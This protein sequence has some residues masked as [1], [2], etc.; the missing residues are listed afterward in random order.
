MSIKL[1]Q[2]ALE[3][4]EAPM[5]NIR[6]TRAGAKPVGS[7]G[8]NR[9]DSITGSQPTRGCNRVIAPGGGAFIGP[10]KNIVMWR[11]PSW[12]A[13]LPSFSVFFMQATCL[14]VEQSVGVKTSEVPW[15]ASRRDFDLALSPLASRLNAVRGHNP[16]WLRPIS[17]PERSKM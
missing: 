12:S 14:E 17:L 5:A 16:L 11:E 7:I 13:K 1:R 6:G 9:Q 3:G 2:G 8:W 10:G 4:L 15:S